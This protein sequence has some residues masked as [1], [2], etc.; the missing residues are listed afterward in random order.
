ML[1]VFLN[2]VLVI[3]YIRTICFV[4]TLNYLTPKIIIFCIIIMAGGFSTCW[5]VGNIT[6]VSKSSGP[7]TC[8]SDYHHHFFFFFFFFFP[9]LKFF[10]VKHLNTSSEKNKLFPILLIIILIKCYCK[11]PKEK[12]SSN[13]DAKTA[14]QRCLR[15]NEWQKTPLSQLAE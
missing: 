13:T 1:C 15:L 14:E 10:L 2:A 9:V 12:S 6:P 11:D 8:P 4:K 3:P 7:N 5:Q